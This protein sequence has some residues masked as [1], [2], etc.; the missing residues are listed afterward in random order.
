MKVIMFK[1]SCSEYIK[2]YLEPENLLIW[3]YHTVEETLEAMK[4]E[5]YKSRRDIPSGAVHWE[6][7]EMF[8]TNL[9]F[10]YANSIV[11]Y[12]SEALVEGESNG[13]A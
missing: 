3:C 8:A 10:D 5:S 9:A 11:A 6:S 2:A 13:L 4:P 1:T 7:Q 12:T